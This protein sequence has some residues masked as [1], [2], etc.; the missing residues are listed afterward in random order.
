M[1][2]LTSLTENLVGI[3][4]GF[5]KSINNNKTSFTLLLDKNLKGSYSSIQKDNLFR[6]DKI[7]F[8]SAINLNYTNL[9]RLISSEE[10]CSRLRAFIID[11]NKPEFEKSLQKQYILKNKHLLKKLNQSQQEAIIRVK[12]IFPQTFC[13]AF[14]LTSFLVFNGKGLPSN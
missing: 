5:V 10:K 2:L 6:I 7:N 9:S 8:R 14:Y 11:K 4:Q 3:S 1:I 12:L 13:R